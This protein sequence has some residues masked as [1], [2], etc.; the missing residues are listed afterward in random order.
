MTS[1]SFGWT[2]IVRL[3]PRSDNAGRDHRPHDVH[4]QSRD[5]C[6]TRLTSGRS[7]AVGRLALRHSDFEAGLGLWVG[8]RRAPDAVD[9]RR[10]GRPRAR[11]NWGCARNGAGSEFAAS[12]RVGRGAVFSVVGDWRGFGGNLGPRDARDPCR[13]APAGLRRIRR[14]D[15]DDFGLCDFGAPRRQLSRSIFEHAAHRGDVD[16]LRNRLHRC[17][18]RCLGR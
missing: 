1:A 9:H 4:D 17:D 5:G 13:A 14:L 3:R 16:N 18:T 15:D 8:R 7:R 2:K 11:R 12:R 10:D 6:G